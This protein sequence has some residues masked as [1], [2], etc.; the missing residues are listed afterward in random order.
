[1]RRLGTL[2]GSGQL[3]TEAGNGCEVDYE[4]FVWQQENGIK[5]AAGALRNFEMPIAIEAF[6]SGSH[7]NLK[8]EDGSL[9]KVA[10]SRI[11]GSEEMEVQVSGPVPG[12]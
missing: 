1:M 10:I 7:A 4:I 9:I 12:Y 3:T 5:S 6:N 8:L 11:S 2:V